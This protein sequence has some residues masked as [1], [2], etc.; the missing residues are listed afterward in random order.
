MPF[1]IMHSII[2]DE[3]G[4]QQVWR[5]TCFT[6]PGASMFNFFFNYKNQFLTIF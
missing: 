5:R 2:A 4:A 1:C 3:H 6:P